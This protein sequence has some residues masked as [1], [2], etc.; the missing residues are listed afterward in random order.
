MPGVTPPAFFRT[1]EPG[2]S[3]SVCA[4]S[5]NEVLYQFYHIL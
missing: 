5:C 2:I 1:K 3:A 4:L